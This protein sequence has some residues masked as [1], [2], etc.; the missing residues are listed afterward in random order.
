[1]SVN[2]MGFT[3]QLA[4][5]CAAIH[6][7]IFVFFVIYLHGISDGQSQMLWMLFLV[8]DFPVSLL[9]W[10]GYDF[11]PE[12]AN[13]IRF[14]LPYFVHGILGTLWWY[15]FPSGLVHLIKKMVR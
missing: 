1:M 4:L 5:W 2:Q 11:L 14:Y 3:M 15:Y 9:V 13:T 7:I 6:A 8:I 10:Y 12:N